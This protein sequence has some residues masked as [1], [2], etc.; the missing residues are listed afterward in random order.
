[1]SDT[2]LAKEYQLFHDYFGTKPADFFT[3][4]QMALDAAFINQDQKEVLKAKLL[5]NPHLSSQ[6]NKFIDN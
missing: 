2:T 1:M 6:V 5:E 4:N 3:Y